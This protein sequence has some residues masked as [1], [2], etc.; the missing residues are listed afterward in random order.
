MDTNDSG[1]LADEVR[2]VQAFTDLWDWR[3]RV[4]DLYAEIRA[5]PGRPGWELWRAGRDR[6]F[7]DHPQSPLG[8]NERAR[9]FGPSGDCG[10]SAKSLSR[11]ARHSSHPGRPGAARISA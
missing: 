8:P 4:D 6:L 11:P 3:R 5:A 7:A 2:T 10:W 9:S 1:R